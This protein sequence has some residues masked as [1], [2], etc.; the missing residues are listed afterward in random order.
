MEDLLVLLRPA[1]S[2]QNGAGISGKT[3]A[4]WACWKGRSGLIATE[5]AVGKYARAA[6]CQKERE[7]SRLSRS[8]DHKG[9]ESQGGQEPH[10]GEREG[11]QSES[12]EKKGWIP[13]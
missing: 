4:Y 10:L 2:L 13:Q 9:G 3:R 8:P 5:R 1:K 7:Q 12:M 11:D 6:S